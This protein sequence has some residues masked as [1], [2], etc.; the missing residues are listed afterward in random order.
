MTIEQLYLGRVINYD[1]VA[2]I[3]LTTAVGTVILLLRFRAGL[4]TFC[5]GKKILN[6]FLKLKLMKLE[7]PNNRSRL[8]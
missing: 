3:R 4:P 7:Q 5:D 6:K 8:V 1:R 2:F